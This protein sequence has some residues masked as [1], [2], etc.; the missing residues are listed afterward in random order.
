[1][2]AD[3]AL[4]QP[5]CTSEEEN[6]GIPSLCQVYPLPGGSSSELPVQH[7]GSSNLVLLTEAA[8][9]GSCSAGITGMGM[10]APF[11]PLPSGVLVTLPEPPAPSP[12][13]A[14]CLSGFSALI[15]P[16]SGS[17]LLPQGISS[18][19]SADSRG[20]GTRKIG[21]FLQSFVCSVPWRICRVGRAPRAPKLP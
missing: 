7:L 18:C 13:P 16:I 19:R 10:V 14:L 3:P 20:D 12:C 8:Q 21:F 5:C 2:P 15:I 1:M 4:S 11:L 6:V 17:L 9:A